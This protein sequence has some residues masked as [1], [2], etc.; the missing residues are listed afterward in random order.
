LKSDC[1]VICGVMRQIR[2]LRQAWPCICPRGAMKPW[3]RCWPRW[4]S[5]PKRSATSL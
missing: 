4:A 5:S 3:G 2:R 1:L